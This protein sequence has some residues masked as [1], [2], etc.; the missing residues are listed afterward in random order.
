MS[1]LAIITNIR[2]ELED[3]FGIAPTQITY[4]E[5]YPGTKAI[6]DF[7]SKYIALGSREEAEAAAEI[8]GC[9]WVELRVRGLVIRSYLMESLMG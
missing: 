8:L 6:F 1:N 2:A 9:D 4:C 7:R 5:P 3:R